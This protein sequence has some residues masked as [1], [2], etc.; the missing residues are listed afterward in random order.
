MMR[1]ALL[2]LRQD[3]LSLF[4][5]SCAYKEVNDRFTGLFLSSYFTNEEEIMAKYVPVGVVYQK[6][7][8]SGN[9]GCLLMIFAL[10]LP[11]VATACVFL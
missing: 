8:N 3:I 6:V 2:S 11:V 5:F 9:S 4:I 1:I 10:I 7:P